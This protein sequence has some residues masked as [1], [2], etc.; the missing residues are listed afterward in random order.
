MKDA[1]VRAAAFAWLEEQTEVHDHSLPRT[2]LA[3]GFVFQGERIP[4]V[5]PQ[6]IF[7]PR[8]L[9]LPLTIT[10]VFGGPYDDAFGADGLLQYKYRGENIAHPANAGVRELMKRR[11]PLI[12]FHGIS[13]GSYVPSW[14]AFVVGDNPAALTFTIAVDDSATVDA[15]QGLALGAAVEQESA[16]IRRGYITV[17]AK[18]RIHQ[19]AFRAR[20]VTAYR[21]QCALCR[22]KHEVLLD[23]AHIVPDSDPDGE[24]VTSNGMAL[25]KIHHAAYDKHFLSVTPDYRIHIKQSLLEE[26]DGPM[27]KH[28]LQGLHGQEIIVPQ[29]FIDRPNKIALEARHSRFLAANLPKNESA[30]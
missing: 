23:A 26:S 12:Y 14:P 17:L 20:V 28:G 8:V 5:S 29:K 2:L 7:K 3:T 21:Q 25:C 19:E 18:R 27:L 15:A 30:L 13:A 6:G 9:D 16:A 22:L 1:E 10:T 11:I 4:L 24:P